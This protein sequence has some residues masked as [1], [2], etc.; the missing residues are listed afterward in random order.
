LEF[1][2][3]KIMRE[4]EQIHFGSQMHLRMPQ[5]PFDEMPKRYNMFEYVRRRYWRCVGS[6]AP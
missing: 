4:D 1:E 2:G 3:L 6:F 5:W